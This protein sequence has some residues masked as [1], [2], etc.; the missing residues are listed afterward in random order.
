MG[1]TIFSVFA[2]L[3]RIAPQRIIKIASACLQ[4]FW[5]SQAPVHHT[6]L[7]R[8]SSSPVWVKLREFSMTIGSGV[9]P[10]GR[11][12]LPISNVARNIFSYIFF[13]AG[14]VCGGVPCVPRVRQVA[15]LLEIY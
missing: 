8:H 6:D 12:G 10:A 9:N 11:T 5:G 15:I 2:R 14:A 7:E 1:I 13:I 3:P 4:L